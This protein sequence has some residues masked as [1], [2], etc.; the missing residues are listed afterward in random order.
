M[1]KGQ[2]AKE[3]VSNI[4]KKAFGKDYILTYNNKIYIWAD[5]GGERIQIA[6]SLTCPKT[7]V[8]VDVAEPKER[9]A[10]DDYLTDDVEKANAAAAEITN[11]EK[12]TI[13]DLR[14]TLGF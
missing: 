1:A 14:R 11:K 5:D 8:G 2:I 7:L 6:I 4:I 3:Q 10:F 13:A 12:E 9:S